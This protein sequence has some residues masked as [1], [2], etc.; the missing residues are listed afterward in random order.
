MVDIELAAVGRNMAR[1]RAERGLRLSDLAEATGY[2]TSH[3][4]Q[5]ERGTSIPSLTALAMVAMALD[6]E[7][8]ALLDSSSGPLV[9]V[10]RAGEG[11]E[12]R[13]PDGPLW[14]VIGS[15]GTEGAYTA[16][17]L[18]TSNV[19]AKYRHFGERFILMLRGSV[20]ISFGEHHHHLTTG[21][22]LHYSAHEPHEA[23]AQ[24]DDPL[25]RM[26]VIASPALF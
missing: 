20:F 21:D 4:S 15:H 2:T 22:T 18:R 7:M 24:T 25:G 13:T 17:I 16:V 5:I 26:L 8:T 19:P 3:L 9:H 14:R 1:I 11:R 23:G 12:L 6:V 10:T